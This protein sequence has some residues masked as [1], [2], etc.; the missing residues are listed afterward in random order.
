MAGIAFGL[1]IKRFTRPGLFRYVGWTLLVLSAVI[2]AF[3]GVND[4]VIR[5]LE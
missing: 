1:L 5:F 3:P 2:Y 4:V